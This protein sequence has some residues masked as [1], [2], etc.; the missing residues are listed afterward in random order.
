MGEADKKLIEK[1]EEDFHKISSKDGWTREDIEN[2]KDL[3]KLM[4]YMEVR[5]AMKEGGEY[6]GSEYMER[7]GYD[8]RQYMG[9]GMQYASRNQ[10]RD[11]M[12]RY[13]DSGYNNR[14][15]YN[16]GGRYGYSMPMPNRMYYGSERENS[17]NELRRMAEMEQNPEAR[18]AMEHAM[19]I[20]EMK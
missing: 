17:V 8:T 13:N 10:S 6:P 20:L 9:H 5:C 15:Q 18:E 7:A 16:S 12:G 11:S 1:F 3:E 19:R 4:Y 2:M 14:G